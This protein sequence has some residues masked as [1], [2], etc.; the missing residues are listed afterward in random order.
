M[1]DLTKGSIIRLMLL[2]SLPILL[3][4][5]FQQAY[6]LVDII[7]VGKKLGELSLSA[8][9]STTAVVSLMFNII[10]GLCTGFAIPVAKHYGANDM[11]KVRRLQRLSHSLS[12]LLSVS[13]ILSE[14]AHF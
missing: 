6:N 5:L 11:N 9:G 7:I 13:F 2:F 8:V 4:S 12:P 3:G 1:R 14:N 10:N